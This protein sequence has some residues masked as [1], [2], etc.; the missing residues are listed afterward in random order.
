MVPAAPLLMSA[1]SF[2]C[3]YTLLSLLAVVRCLRLIDSAARFDDAYTW[4]TN[5]PIHFLTLKPLELPRRYDSPPD[6]VKPPG[7]EELQA[8]DPVRT[9][10]TELIP[11]GPPG[12]AQLEAMPVYYGAIV[13][14][15]VPSATAAEPP[16]PV[17]VERNGKHRRS[18]AAEV[19]A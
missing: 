5:A 14:S 4:I 15:A 8:G 7:R 11:P 10:V 18:D 16:P 6:S 19:K 1:M 12:A 17:A 9:D 13:D 3:T 2:V